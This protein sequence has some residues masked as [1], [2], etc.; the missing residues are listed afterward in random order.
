DPARVIPI[1]VDCAATPHG[2]GL[3]NGYF[4]VLGDGNR[5]LVIET[6]PEEGQKLGDAI[7]VSF[8][9]AYTS[10]LESEGDYPPPDDGFLSYSGIVQTGNF[11]QN[12]FEGTLSTTVAIADQIHEEDT[13]VI[14]M[15]VGES[16][17]V[18]VFANGEAHAAEPHYL[19]RVAFQADF[20][21]KDLPSN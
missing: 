18:S 15:N 16:I 5:G 17:L 21:F 8:A 2:M 4:S 20:L 6:Q 12:L 19:N 9:F 7:Q 3:H 10:T 13:V 1:A 11:S 14:P